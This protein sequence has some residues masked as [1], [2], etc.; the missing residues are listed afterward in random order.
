MS[1]LTVSPAPARSAPLPVTLAAMRRSTRAVLRSPTLLVTPVAQSLFFLLI[2]SGQLSAVGSGYLAGGSFVSFLLPLIL[3]TGVAT[4][5]GAAGTLVLQDVTSGYLDRLRLAHGTATPFLIGAVFAALVAVA[6]QLLVT[7][8]GAALIGYRPESWAGMTAMLLLMLTLGLG[9]ALLSI[10]VAIRTA[11]ASSTNL[12]TLA[13]FGLSFFTG[14]FAPV[15]ELAGWMRAIATVNPLTYVV[16]AARQLESGAT[17]SA[18]PIASVALVTL[19]LA[20]IAAC[21]LA[22]NHARRNR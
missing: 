10:A 3:L 11:S 6:I 20:G 18:A 14:V 9:I 7:V 22:L 19:A 17:L 2:Y 1:L 15:D 13:V 12:V 8:A 21:A 16:D 5:A 4:G